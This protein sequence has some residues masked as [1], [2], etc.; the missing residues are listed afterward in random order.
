[1]PQRPRFPPPPVQARLVLAQAREKGVSFDEAWRKRVIGT[2]TARGLVRYPHATVERRFWKAT[3]EAQREEWRSA[4]ERR[5]SPL[6]A[7]VVVLAALLADDA[8]SAAETI[9]DRAT[10][11]MARFPQQLIVEG[12]GTPRRMQVAA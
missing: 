12:V 10:A 3:L 5:P 6:G 7:A 9:E 11:R 8:S 1:M 4:Y 2:Q